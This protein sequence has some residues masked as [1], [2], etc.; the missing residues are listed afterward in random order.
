MRRAC[1]QIENASA[2][3]SATVFTATSTLGYPSS[4]PFVGASRLN[5]LSELLMDGVEVELDEFF[6]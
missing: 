1:I 2:R 5:E 3:F 4:R 6:C